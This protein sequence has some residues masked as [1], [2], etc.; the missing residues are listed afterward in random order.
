MK[1][2]IPTAGGPPGNS[3]NSFE[4]YKITKVTLQEETVDNQNRPMFVKEQNLKLKMTW[5]V[6]GRS[7]EG[8]SRGRD[9]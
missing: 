3:T 5:L 7:V 2:W 8:G 6:M 1:V 9:I 4:R